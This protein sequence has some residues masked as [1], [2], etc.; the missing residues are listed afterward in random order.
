MTSSSPL[1]KNTVSVALSAL[2]AAAISCA[3]NH[4]TPLFSASWP[5]SLIY[6]SGLCIVLNLVYAFQSG[7]ASFS[8]LLLAGIVI[9]L[10]LA[11]IIILVIAVKYPAGAFNLSIHFISHYILFTIFEI[12]YL[13]QLIK[14]NTLKSHTP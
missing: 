4:Y 10:L 5:Y 3:L 11:L 7:S 8:Q 9:K 6:F 14:I 1:I 13:L 12:R 2:S